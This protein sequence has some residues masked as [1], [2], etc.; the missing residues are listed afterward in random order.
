[1]KPRP[2]R[3]DDQ[4]CFALYAATNAVTRAYR[5]VL[6]DLGLTY[7]QYLVM[8][9]LWQDGAS[10]VGQ[11]A[12]RLNLAPSAITPLV[13]RLVTADLVAREIDPDDRRA[14]QV[15]L[16]QN[17]RDLEARTSLA[18]QAVECQTGLAPA[19]LAELRGALHALVERMQADESA[20]TERV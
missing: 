8:L 4:L 10:P 3:L 15:S 1:M 9:V 7:P 18:Q 11:I 19:D 5:P 2:L 13:D 17:G 16:T 6:G 20:A 14:I 12:R